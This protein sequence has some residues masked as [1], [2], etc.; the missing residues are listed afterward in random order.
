MNGGVTFHRASIDF[1]F[2]STDGRQVIEIVAGSHCRR[3][4]LQLMA[5]VQG[6]HHEKL[7]VDLT[8][9]NQSS[10]SSA[11]NLLASTQVTRSSLTQRT[12][13]SGLAWLPQ[14]ANASAR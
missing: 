5:A 8:P 7:V 1:K 12:S 11:L 14:F 10:D 2:V 13:P 9:R 6:R 3:W 4:R